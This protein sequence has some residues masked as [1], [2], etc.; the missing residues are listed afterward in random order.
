MLTTVAISLT[1]AYWPEAGSM[2]AGSLI[3]IMLAVV[4]VGA[5]IWVLAWNS[6][7]SHLKG[8]WCP[9]HRRR[10]RQKEVTLR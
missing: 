3:W 1:L 10:A 4:V 8:A 6:R 5:L 7:N 2:P 9:A